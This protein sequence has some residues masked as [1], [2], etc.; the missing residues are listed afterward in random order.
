MMQCIASRYIKYIP[1]KCLD[2]CNVSA[3]MAIPKQYSRHRYRYGPNAINSPQK[4]KSVLP[5][6]S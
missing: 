4:L 5:P 6:T 2:V 3:P 1:T